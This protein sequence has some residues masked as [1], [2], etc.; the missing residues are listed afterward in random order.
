MTKSKATPA[1]AKTKGK[2]GK[3]PKGGGGKAGRTWSVDIPIL[4]R[5][6]IRAGDKLLVVGPAKLYDENEI[7]QQLPV[8]A[9][10]KKIVDQAKKWETEAE[11]LVI[12]PTNGKVLKQA[13]LGF[14][15]VWDGVAVAKESLFVSGADGTLY[16]LK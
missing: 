2:K 5:S 15:P 3:R 6:I 12:D 14:A 16:R 13:K 4:A 8:P 10:S 11:V 7:I 9:A 1:S